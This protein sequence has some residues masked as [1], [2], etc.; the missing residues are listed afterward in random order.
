MK[1]FRILS[2]SLL[3]AVAAAPVAFAQA[4]NPTAAAEQGIGQMSLWQTLLAGG[5][6]M[7]IIALLS[8]IGGAIIIYNFMNLS[9]EKMAP[10]AFTKK[11][12]AYLESKNVEEARVLCIKEQNNVIA[13]IALAGLDKIRKN[14]KSSS[15][16]KDTI[17]HK[18]H[19]EIGGLWQNLNYLADIVTI[20]PLLGLLG[21]VLG[22]IKTFKAVPLQ[23]V[24][25]KTALLAAGI[26]QAMVTTATSLVVAILALIAYSY[27]RGRIQQ[28][29][30]VL[31]MYTT[32]LIKAME[33]V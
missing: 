30:D 27:F 17:E 19:I 13:R 26:S 31:E 18:A 28:V 6:T 5:L 3:H 22:M 8:I 23:T 15:V 21:T 32:D 2:L 11:L 1:K 24:S 9:V 14:V 10:R 25:L 29:T 7:L 4:V 12:L 16:I 20:A 33:S